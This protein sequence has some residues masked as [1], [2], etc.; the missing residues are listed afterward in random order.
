MCVTRL[1]SG[2]GGVGGN[3]GG[4]T[5]VHT[6][7]EQVVDVGDG[8]TAAEV[9]LDHPN[10][11]LVC[12]DSS[13]LAPGKRLVALAAHQDLLPNHLYFLMPMHKLRGRLSA[14]DVGRLARLAH[15]L[16]KRPPWPRDHF[17]LPPSAFNGGAGVSAYPRLQ[18]AAFSSK[19]HLPEP[20]LLSTFINRT[21]PPASLWRPTLQTIDETPHLRSWTFR[22]G[23]LIA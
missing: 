1:R 6:G 10:H 22:E 17:L 5:V 3:G 11:F 13:A 7:T 21:P 4:V 2:C 12:G 19:D 20:S 9:M 14:Q 15:R 18:Q 8:A 16:L 23:L